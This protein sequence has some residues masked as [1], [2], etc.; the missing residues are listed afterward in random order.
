MVC[1]PGAEVRIAQLVHD[2][3]GFLEAPLGSLEPI[4]KE[5]GERE[6]RQGLAPQDQQVPVRSDAAGTVDRVE[7]SLKRPLRLD[8]A[9]GAVVGGGLVP[10]GARFLEQ[11]DDRCLTSPLRAGVTP[12]S[13]G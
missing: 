1:H 13:W 9:P 3:G 12:R 6:G 8:G 4:E 5:V 7:G 10:E 2:P 11:V